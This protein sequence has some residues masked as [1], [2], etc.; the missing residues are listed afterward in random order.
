MKFRLDNACGVDALRLKIK[1]ICFYWLL[2]AKE[3][4]TANKENKEI[5]TKEISDPI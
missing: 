3:K 5:E 4:K 2:L 1:I